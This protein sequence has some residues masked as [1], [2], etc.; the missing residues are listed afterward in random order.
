MKGYHIFLF[1]LIIIFGYSYY[2]E[3]NKVIE[4]NS[5][6]DSKK[7]IQNI[8]NTTG[9]DTNKYINSINIIENKYELRNICEDYK[10]M[11]CFDP[12]NKNI[13]ILNILNFKETCNDFNYTIY[14]EIGHAYGE[15]YGNTSEEYADDFAHTYALDKCESPEYLILEKELKEKELILNNSEEILKKWDIYKEI[16]LNNIKEYYTDY[17]YYEQ[18]VKDYNYIIHKINILNRYEDIPENMYKTKCNS[19]KY[20]NLLYTYTDSIDK[21]NYWDKYN[22]VP[23]E[24]YENYKKDYQ[25]YLDSEDN[26]ISSCTTEK[27]SFEQNNQYIKNYYVTQSKVTTNYVNNYDNIRYYDTTEQNV[28]YN[29]TK[30]TGEYINCIYKKDDVD[31]KSS[32]CF[33]NGYTNIS[34][35][36]F[37][38]KQN[39]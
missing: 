17:R 37:R 19:E 25:K 1:I 15:K 7:I 38:L 11:G 34:L 2:V 23:E 39:L 24:Y 6:N 30:L 5:D 3:S 14:H 9:K 35:Y 21:L 13:Y 27:S 8:I 26:F 4:I 18:A 29:N 16:P 20:Y 32:K 28:Y 10:A 31:Y 12:N 22:S 33:K 36:S